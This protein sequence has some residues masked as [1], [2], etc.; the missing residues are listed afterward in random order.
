MGEEAS[1]QFKLR[2]VDETKNYLLK[3]INHNNVISEKNKKTC[4]Y[5]NY[6]E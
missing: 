2:K 1:L 4:K 3:E 6:V 5:L